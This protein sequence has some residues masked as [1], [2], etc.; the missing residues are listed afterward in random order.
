ML[1]PGRG[2]NWSIQAP[3][4]K[5]AVSQ[6]RDCSW[7][8]VANQASSRHTVWKTVLTAYATVIVRLMMHFIF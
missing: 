8:R 3:G 4:N 1:F 7:Q 6:K 2:S 5:P